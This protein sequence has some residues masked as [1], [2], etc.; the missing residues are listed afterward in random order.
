MLDRVKIY[1]RAGD[2]GNGCN[3]YKGKKFTRSR[4]PDGG[5][6]GRGGD[7]VIRVDRNI[8]TLEHLQFKPHIRAENGKPGLANKRKGADGRSYIIK[9]PQGT[10]VRDVK[11]KL[12]LRD[13]V[14]SE[15]EFAV[16][17]GGTGGQ[18]NSRTK[19]ATAGLHGEEKSILLE[20]KIVADIG[21]I[22]YPNV[23]KSTLLTKISSARPKIASYPFTTSS[24][25]LAALESAD[26]TEPY[27][28]IVVEIPALIRGAGEGK[29]LGTQFLRH[30][31]RSKILIH[32][33]D[34][35]ASGERDPFADY[36]NVNREL[37]MYNLNLG[38]KTQILVANKMD[39]PEAKRNLQKFAL[40]A[41]KKIYPVKNFENYSSK[42]DITNGIYSISAKEDRGINELVSCI[43]N[44][45]NNEAE[46]ATKS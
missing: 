17:K 33:I 23:G 35:A 39:L 2:G 44:Y 4:H 9:V 19:T 8:Q 14:E 37:R 38:N 18:G 3:S 5:H 28:L 43:R 29:G 30:A 41:K 15:E 7:I 21:I 11:N 42:I 40:K 12:L 13:L 26:F 32:L 27:T 6:G 45:F 22:G 25:I 36:L 31:E 24:P 1:V 10:T 16:A 46:I 34:M 20:W